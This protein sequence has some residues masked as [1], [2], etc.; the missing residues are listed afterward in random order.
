M[1]SIIG[2]LQL[3]IWCDACTFEW[4]KATLTYYYYQN[5]VIGSFVTLFGL[6]TNCLVKVW[7]C[8][9]HALSQLCRDSS[10][11]SLLP[12]TNCTGDFERKFQCKSTFLAPPCP[13]PPILPLMRKKGPSELPYTRFS[14]KFRGAR[15]LTWVLL[16][17]NQGLAVHSKFKSLTTS[18]FPDVPPVSLSPID[19]RSSLITKY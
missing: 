1:I 9:C 18:Q 19:N 16:D 10:R 5:F 15:S 6:F 12:L 7:R 8:L 4:L 14:R 3:A 17:F 13:T 11:C 2:P